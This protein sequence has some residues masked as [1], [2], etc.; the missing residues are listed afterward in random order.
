MAVLAP[1]GFKETTSDDWVRVMFSIHSLIPYTGSSVDHVSTVELHQSTVHCCAKLLADTQP[2][3]CTPGQPGN[4]RNK[5]FSMGTLQVYERQTWTRWILVHA[6]NI[7][8]TKVIF[9]HM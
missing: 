5:D 4:I 6:R 3:F 1:F 7:S 8:A 9:K 2:L